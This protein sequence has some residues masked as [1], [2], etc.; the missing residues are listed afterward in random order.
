[1][2]AGKFA[3]IIGKVSEH[4]GLRRI[5]EA[6][7]RASDGIEPMRLFCKGLPD[8]R[9]GHLEVGLAPR[10]ASCK[11]RDRWLTEQPVA[12]ASCCSSSAG[13]SCCT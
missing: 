4:V 7:V 10:R 1:M 6:H 5:S 3:A 12:K 9:A 2:T 8:G 13:S 11:P